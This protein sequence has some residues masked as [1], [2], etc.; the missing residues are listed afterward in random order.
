MTK[1]D[2]T[3]EGNKV[4]LTVEDVDDVE[5]V[6]ETTTKN[7]RNAQNARNRKR[8]EDSESSES[9]GEEDDEDNE[10][11][12]EE[13]DSDFEESLRNAL[14]QAMK[15]TIMISIQM[16]G[17]EEDEDWE[18]E[19]EDEDEED[20]DD[21]DDE[22]NQESE[23][24]DEEEE[25]KAVNQL[26]RSAGRSRMRA[27]KQI[28]EELK[29]EQEEQNQQEAKKAN[30]AKNTTKTNKTPP[31]KQAT[32]SKSSKS[33]DDEE[34]EEDMP[35]LRRSRRVAKKSQPPKPSADSTDSTSPTK[36]PKNPKNT[37]TKKNAKDTKDKDAKDSD[38]SFDFESAMREFKS[39]FAPQDTD[40]TEQSKDSEGKKPTEQSKSP[41]LPTLLKDKMEAL[42]KEYRKREERKQKQERRKQL[43]E[44]SKQFR[45]LLRKKRTESDL[46]FFRK[47]PL[48]TQIKY[49]EE[50][51]K[52]KD[53]SS[54]KKPY[55][56]KLIESPI[57]VEFKSV[58]FKKVAMLETMEPG[59]GEYFKVKQWVDT[60]MRIPFGVN[61]TLPVSLETDGVEKCHEFMGKSKETLDK[62][63]YGLNDAKMQILQLLG[64]L[65]TNPSSVGTAI[66][67]KGPMGTG[68]TTLV[69]EGISK[70]LGRP[71][72]FV[73]LGGATDSSYLEGHS[74]TYEGST[75]GHIVEAIVQCK[76]MNPVFYFD[77]L[78]KVSN[79][80]RGEEII[81]ILTHL[82]DTT[83]NTQYHD[84]YFADLDFDL[85]KALFIFSYNHE[86]LVNPILRDRM[87]CIET[88]GYEKKDKIVIARKYLI[89]KVVESVKFQPEDIE[90]TNE[91][92]DELIEHHT[93]NEKGVRNLKRC[94]ETIFTKLNL[95]RLMPKGSTLFEKDL[96]LHV[97]FP[98]TVTS[99]VVKKLV[100]KEDIKNHS[101]IAMYV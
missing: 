88:K 42:E 32:R 26:M 67:I 70:V 49:I 33:S 94:L 21:E 73:P 55:T 90:I 64:Q 24:E 39:Y 31:K 79:T 41:K 68:K 92:L 11:E 48:D 63:V 60:F 56:I 29:E 87:Y 62:S 14:Q 37:K 53:A 82:T 7:T 58:A 43:V 13:L 16:E 2:Q 40:K 8:I 44:N 45:E 75:W 9:S 54:I 23:E 27:R 3:N 98:F 20:E 86:E 71:F 69:K 66:A 35:I 38:D 93:D 77:E 84:K 17:D 100:K 97:E 25:H 80:P 89:P 46:S 81:G 34:Q 76:C 18:P 50:F 10:D 72:V 19:E 1:R 47:L 91:V 78:D 101:F 28:R 96:E 36:N 83:Q 85:S 5:Q 65:M 74:Y 22:D 61:H 15:N 4:A 99:D 59:F 57:P 6:D 12:E 51:K 95:Y 52:L 30:K